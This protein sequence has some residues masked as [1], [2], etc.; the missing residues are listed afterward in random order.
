MMRMSDCPNSM[1]INHSERIATLEND[2]ENLKDRV[3]DLSIIKDAVIETKTYIK[4][5]TKAQEEQSR[6]MSQIT[7]TM[8]K[9]NQTLDKLNEK[10]DSTDEKV[11]DLNNKFQV[12]LNEID[13]KSKIDILKMAKDWTPK[14]II[15]GITYYILQIVG[16]IKF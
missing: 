14:L 6:T 3:D 2:V 12:K 7:E 4:I 15:G 11:D 16:V 13:D 1:Q 9:Q 8:N 10:I 5:L